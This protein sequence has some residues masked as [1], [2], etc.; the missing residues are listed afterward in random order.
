M[1]ISESLDQANGAP[2]S[3]VC[4]L[5]ESCVGQ[6]WLNSSIS[7][8]LSYW[9][10]AAQGAHSLFLVDTS[11]DPKGT[12]PGGSQLIT[13]FAACSHCKGDMNNTFH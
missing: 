12:A 9:L 8:M 6:A 13:L 5:E 7:A 11:M 1:Q 10:R 3:K 4:P 2:G